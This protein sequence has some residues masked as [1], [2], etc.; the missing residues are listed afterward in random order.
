MLNVNWAEIQEEIDTVEKGY[1]GAVVNQYASLFNVSKDTVYRELRK[2]FGRKKTVKREK[3]IS[4]DL[5]NEIAK[6]KMYGIK[7]QL[8]EREISTE[9]CIELL[10]EKQ[11]PGAENLTISTVNRRLAEK[12]FRIRDGIVRLEADYVNQEHQLDFSRSKF[13]QLFQRDGENWLLRISGKELHYKDDDKKLR[14]WLAGIIDSYSR[15]AIVQAYPASGESSA[16]GIQFLGFAYTRPKDEHPFRSLPEIL[17]TDNGVFIKDRSTKALLEMLNITSKTAKPYSHRGIQKIESLWKKVWKQF[18]LPLAMKIGHKAT[19]RLSEYN[20]LIHNF[21]IRQMEK[22]HPVI[23][24]TRKA[25]YLSGL[26]KHPERIVKVDLSEVAFKVV[27][28]VVRDTVTIRLNNITYQCPDGTQGKRIK[29]YKN[30]AGQVVGCLVDEFKKP[31]ILK[32]VPGYRT[33]N[34][35]EHRPHNTYRQDIATQVDVPTSLNNRGADTEHCRIVKTNTKPI[36]STRLFMPSKKKEIKPETVF[37]QT[38]FNEN[39]VF[40]SK[41]A[42]RVY[43]G[44]SL[45][46]NETYA[47]YANV[48]D[49]MLKEDLSKQSI[50]EILFEIKRH[51]LT[52]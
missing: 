41:Y 23:K 44:K 34:D 20:E 40:P 48:F 36:R 15:L 51:V 28:R 14:T 37:D 25:V 4:D 5:I 31:F 3:K 45:P 42:A 11:F 33:Y 24:D 35:F 26:T 50:D 19:I 21:M 30:L 10:Q 12:G 29:I 6:M 17:K 7:M 9:I 32:Q 27:E 38:K 47:D 39:Y 2:R 52:M 8:D 1:K 22:Q 46:V 43:I 49:D 16:L 13:F 18:E